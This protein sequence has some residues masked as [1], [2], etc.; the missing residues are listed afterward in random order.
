MKRRQD[1]TSGFKL[2]VWWAILIVAAIVAVLA[3]GFEEGWAVDLRIHQTWDET[4]DSVRLT[5]YTDGTSSTQTWAD[6]N[7]IDTTLSSLSAAGHF[8]F[9]WVKYDPGDDW[10]GSYFAAVNLKEDG[11][12]DYVPVA[13]AFG[14]TV[15]AAYTLLYSG[16]L[17]VD[18]S[19]YSNVPSATE[20]YGLDTI[21]NTDSLLSLEAFVQYDAG[22]DFWGGL[23]FA[24]DGRI[25]TGVYFDTIYTPEPP[26]SAN[27]CKVWGYLRD[28][29]I[30][31]VRY[32]VVEAVIDKER[33][34]DTCTGDLVF[35][36]RKSTNPTGPAG[37]FE[38]ILIK[39]K[40]LPK[41]KYTIQVRKKG[42]ETV[43]F[44]LTVPDSSTY[45]IQWPTD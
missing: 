23:E 2:A 40:C 37:Y 42:L 4:I 41:T 29:G 10:I 34:L 45:R 3:V 12:L 25:D 14:D 44:P 35:Q 7:Q 26:D 28:L 22:E 18:S 11:L 36:R 16:N 38:L 17:L 30:G 15:N 1:R 27:L 32:A 43:S 6:T 33:I 21:S 19:Y 31:Y 8:V 39:S 5:H 24:I 20:V 13:L 9:L